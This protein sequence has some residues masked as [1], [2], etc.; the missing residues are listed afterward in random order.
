MTKELK[1]ETRKVFSSLRLTALSGSL[2]KVS[3]EEWREGTREVLLMALKP[4]LQKRM[5]NQ[6]PRTKYP[7]LYTCIDTQT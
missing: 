2:V 7:Y 1:M 5:E 3:E 6:S 4:T